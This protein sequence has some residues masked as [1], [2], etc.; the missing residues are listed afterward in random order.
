M[1]THEITAQDC[2]WALINFDS[3]EHAFKFAGKLEQRLKD[4]SISEEERTRIDS[5]LD[6]L[7]SLLFDSMF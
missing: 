4:P 6:E 7:F 2:S 1:S 3:P 5:A